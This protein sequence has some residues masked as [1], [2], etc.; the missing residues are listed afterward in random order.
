M[1]RSLLFQRKPYEQTHILECRFS[2]CAH[3]QKDLGC[4]PFSF[5]L[6]RH[7]G[8]YS[9]LHDRRLPD[10]RGNEL[11]PG[12]IYSAAGKF[13]RLDADELSYERVVV[14]LVNDLADFVRAG[15][16]AD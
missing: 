12:D 16:C 8:L 11:E 3:E 10:S 14:S 1:N 6:D 9:K 13:H 7:V 5:A 15:Y 4:I 2:S